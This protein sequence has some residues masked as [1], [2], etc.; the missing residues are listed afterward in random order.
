MTSMYPLHFAAKHDRSP[1]VF[2]VYREC[3]RRVVANRMRNEA[4]HPDAPLKVDARGALERGGDNVNRM[5]CFCQP[6]CELGGIPAVRVRDKGSK[7][8]GEEAD[9]QRPIRERRLGMRQKC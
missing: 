5:A 4:M 9:S 2:T 6:G 7:F 3:R 1:P 8:R